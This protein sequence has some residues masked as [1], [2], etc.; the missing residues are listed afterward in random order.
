ML[1][2]ASHA[3]GE[4]LESYEPTVGKEPLPC[5]VIACAAVGDNRVAPGQLAEW[6]EYTNDTDSFREERFE[7]RPLPWSTPHRY[8]VE[9]PASFQAFLGYRSARSSADLLARVSSALGLLG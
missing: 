9:T 4:Q 1:T 7:T 2:P 5:P 3:D 8:L 6:K